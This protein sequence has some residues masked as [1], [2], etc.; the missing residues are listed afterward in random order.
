MSNPTLKILPTLIVAITA[1]WVT[2]PV[3]G[4]AVNNQLVITEKSSTSL[5][6]FYNG[7]QLVVNSDPSFADQ[8]L[9]ILPPSFVLGIAEEQWI[10][11][12]NSGLV[13]LLAFFPPFHGI[14]HDWRL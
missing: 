12:E 5:T 3:F 1:A 6:A 11:P 7:S 4:L 13:N 2:Q 14:P 8:W 10:E 9:I